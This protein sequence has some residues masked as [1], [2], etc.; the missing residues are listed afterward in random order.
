VSE[1]ELFAPATMEF[2]CGLSLGISWGI[3]VV[4]G[5]NSCNGIFGWNHGGCRSKQFGFAH[6][7]APATAELSI[8]G[9]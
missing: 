7:G 2:Q 6:R 4:A 8:D 9:S 1:A 5:A 3:Q